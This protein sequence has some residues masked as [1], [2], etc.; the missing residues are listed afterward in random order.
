MKLSLVIAN[1][2]T[3]TVAVPLSKIDTTT[4]PTAVRPNPPAKLQIHFTDHLVHDAYSKKKKKPTKKKKTCRPAQT[5][6]LPPQ[7]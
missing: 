1:I 6:S 4:S 5:A 7:D 2:A 3:G